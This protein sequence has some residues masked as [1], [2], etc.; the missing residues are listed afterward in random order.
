MP[1][2]P[3]SST[4]AVWIDPAQSALIR[5]VTDA[6]GA[7]IVAAGTFAR[8]QAGAVAAGFNA[9]SADDLRSLISTST[10]DAV[11]IAAAGDFVT[12][13][14]ENQIPDDDLRAVI[15]RTDSTAAQQAS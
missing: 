8:G 13:L 6:A 14:V 1:E 12:V 3:S 9:A 11:H 5:E 15:L 4:I 2:G 7:R 10:A